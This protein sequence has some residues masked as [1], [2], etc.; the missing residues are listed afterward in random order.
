MQEATNGFNKARVN[1]EKEGRGRR[2]VM[3]SK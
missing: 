1:D 2:S 3:K